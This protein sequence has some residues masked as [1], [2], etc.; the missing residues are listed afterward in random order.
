MAYALLTLVVLGNVTIWILNRWAGKRDTDVRRLGLCLTCFTAAGSIIMVSITNKPLLSLPAT[1]SGL[2][3]GVA[4]AV[5]YLVIIMKC[6]RIGPAGPTITINNLGLL[7][8]VVLGIAFTYQSNP[9][10]LSTYTG[11]VLSVLAL[12]LM[13]RNNVHRQMRIASEWVRMVIIGF[14]FSCLSFGANFLAT[15]LDPQNPYAFS[16]AMNLSAFLL[17]LFDMFYKKRVR[18][19]KSERRIGLG[20]ALIHVITTPLTFYVTTV[21]PAYIV[22]PVISVAPI[23][24]MLFVGHFVYKERLNVYGYICSILGIAGV[25]LMNF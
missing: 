2:V 16:F 11:I 7:G 22:F 17:L 24:I 3:A 20:I 1:L 21:I 8:S 18:P 13:F 23:V 9:P 6:L 12:L 10:S 4:Y 14:F 15:F 25:I 5:G 19:N